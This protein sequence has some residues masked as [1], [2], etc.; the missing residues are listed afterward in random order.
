MRVIVVAL[1]AGF[2]S[3]NVAGQQPPARRLGGLSPAIESLAG[4]DTFDYYCVSCHG[5]E[6]K[7]DGPLAG[8]LRT[9]VP[10]L[11]TVAQRNA[12]VFPR[13]RVRAAVANTERP[14]TA[15][16][17]G[18][19]P[20]W[21]TLFGVLENSAARTDARIDGVVRYI[22]RMQ[23]P[24]RPSD[25]GRALFATY[26]A[27]CHG[28]DA[29][30]NGPASIALRRDVPDLTRF[31]IRTSGVFPS[32]RVARIIDGRDIVS[33]GTTDMPIWGDAFRHTREGLTPAE[34]DARIVALTSFLETIQQRNGE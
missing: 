18:D 22:E 24:S 6:G 9:A 19:M 16:G 33:H 4:V 15:H 3:M 1:L 34:V 28:V 2:A 32:A 8:A 5:K 21:G 25:Q 29:R 23:Q 7:G 17:T 10:D 11:T 27:S 20:V 14:I 13:E 26:C 30:G 31:A 12:E